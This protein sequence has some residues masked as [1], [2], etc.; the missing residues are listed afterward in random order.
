MCR[1]VSANKETK[2]EA[3]ISVHIE[4][5]YWTHRKMLGFP[6]GR[7]AGDNAYIKERESHAR[8]YHYDVLG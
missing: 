2:T 5:A 3:F 1:K 7:G 4:F 6:M 8:H